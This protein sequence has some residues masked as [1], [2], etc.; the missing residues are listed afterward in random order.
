MKRLFLVV[1]LL[2]VML[3]V[4]AGPVMA[5]GTMVGSP[6]QDDVSGGGGFAELLVEWSTLLG[7]AALITVVVNTGKKIGLVKD[8]QAKNWSAGLNLIGLAALL[9][10]RVIWPELDVAWL[11]DQARQMAEVAAVVIGYVIQLWGSQ[12]V[13]EIL[14]GL[15]L[16]G[17]THE[18]QF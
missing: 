1:S 5:Q 8:G 14:R 9:M 3:M 7:F 15:P 6:V 12:A 17:K 10:T 18:A 11:D 2:V 4:M 16:I 13:H